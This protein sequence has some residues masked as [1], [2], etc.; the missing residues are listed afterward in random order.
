MNRAGVGEVGYFLEMKRSVLL[1]LFLTGLTMA[2]LS[3]QSKWYGG[4]NVSAQFGTITY[5]E[6]SPFVGYRFT[7]KFS[8]GPG[9]TYQ[10][11]EFQGESSSAFG[12]RAFARYLVIEN[13]FLHTEYERLWYPSYEVNTNGE[14]RTVRDQVDSWFAGAGYRQ[15]IG[16]NASFQL[17]VLYNLL[18][19]EANSPYSSPIVIRAGASYGF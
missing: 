19:D 11:W 12:L 18:W 6:A 2:D 16:T 9:A 17:T 8:A 14:V 3:A 4:G 7:D 1:L 10:Y 5:I 15:P 13:L